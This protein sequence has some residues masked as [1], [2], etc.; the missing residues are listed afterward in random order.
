MF[1]K[2][3][4][5][6]PLCFPPHLANKQVSR[7]SIEFTTA[8]NLMSLGTLN[9]VVFLQFNCEWPYHRCDLITT[10]VFISKYRHMLVSICHIR[11]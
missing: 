7:K 9:A 6:T 5:P 2:K 3:N 11:T 4:T 1:K 10:D 8:L